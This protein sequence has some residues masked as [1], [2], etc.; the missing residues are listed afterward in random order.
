MSEIIRVIDSPNEIAAMAAELRGTMGGTEALGE[1]DFGRVRGLGCGPGGT[2]NGPHTRCS[3]SADV[4][5]AWD[6]RT[7]RRAGTWEQRTVRRLDGGRSRSTESLSLGRGGSLARGKRRDPACALH[8]LRNGGRQRF[9]GPRA[10]A[11]PRTH[12]TYHGEVGK[13]RL[14]SVC[15][16]GSECW[17]SIM[18]G[19]T[20]RKQWLVPWMGQ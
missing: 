4:V 3:I 17:S 19:G 8:D 6:F 15:R 5:E 16:G 1:C 20:C 13:G 9:V 7:H 18:P 12:A 10:R 14:Q 2:G 11:T